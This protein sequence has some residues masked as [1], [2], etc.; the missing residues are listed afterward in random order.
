MAPFYEH[1]NCCDVFGVELLREPFMRFIRIGVRHKRGRKV[2][3]RKEAVGTD[4]H[5][6]ERK[7]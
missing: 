4:D 5:I 7:R 3:D 6:G 2:E 1:C